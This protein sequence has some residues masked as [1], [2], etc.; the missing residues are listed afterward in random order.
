VRF[1]VAASGPTGPLLQEIRMVDVA[2][3]NV[4]WYF[5]LL[6]MA[7]QTQRRVPFIQQALVDGPVRRVANGAALPQCLMLI[8]KRAALLC[9]TLKAGFVSAEESKTAGFKLLLNICRSSF[10]RHAFMHFVTIGTAHFAFRNGVMMRQL[11]RRANFEVTL[12]ASLR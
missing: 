2:N 4:P 12:K 5:L 7:F 1:F 10:D 3:E 8:H 11:K 6:E 9:V